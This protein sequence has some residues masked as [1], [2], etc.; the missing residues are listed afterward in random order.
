M[1]APD[2]D[3]VI[4]DAAPLIDA[5][6]AKTGRPRE[7]YEAYLIRPVRPGQLWE[8][9]LYGRLESLAAGPLPMHVKERLRR[10]VRASR[11]QSAE[12]A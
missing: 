8:D 1:T 10:Q 11:P 5:R 6:V 7:I 2:F 12:A 4:A 3:Q 9:A